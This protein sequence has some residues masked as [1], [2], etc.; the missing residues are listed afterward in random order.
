[1]RS[2]KRQQ[3]INLIYIA[4]AFLFDKNDEQTGLKMQEALF[5]FS[6]LLFY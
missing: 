1:M 3:G 4:V 5:A 2:N 6:R